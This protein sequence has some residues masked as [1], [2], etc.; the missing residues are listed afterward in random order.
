MIYDR[1]LSR[2]RE[3]VPLRAKQRKT[4]REATR[5]RESPILLRNQRTALRS[6]IFRGKNEKKG[7]AIFLASTKGSE[8]HHVSQ[9]LPEKWPAVMNTIY[10]CLGAMHPS[11]D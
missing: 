5:Q 1:S 10:C 4:Q 11:F 6:Y 9:G 8:N 7:K 2:R 3:M